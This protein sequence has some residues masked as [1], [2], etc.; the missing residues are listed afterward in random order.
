MRKDL[1]QKL[2][3]TAAVEKKKEEECL[4]DGMTPYTYM[5]YQ[6]SSLRRNDHDRHD[7]GIQSGPAGHYQQG[8]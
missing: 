1:V 7:T 2:A 4:I 5:R 8:C 6:R 3:G